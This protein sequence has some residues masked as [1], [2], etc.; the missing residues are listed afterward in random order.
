MAQIEELRRSAP[1]A[2]WPEQWRE[3][4]Q[5]AGPPAW[6]CMPPWFGWPPVGDPPGWPK[7]EKRSTYGA[8][9]KAPGGS[10]R[11]TT[12][13]LPAV[14]NIHQAAEYLKVS[15]ATMYILVQ[16]EDFPG[17]RIGKIWRIDARRLG[18]WVAR[19]S[20]GQGAGG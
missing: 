16:R 7:Q 10:D 3:G 8:E 11:P 14:L 6:Y 4:F 19:Q 17:F 20:G 9:E 5:E 12:V 18:E 1:P 13:S 15:E 2:N